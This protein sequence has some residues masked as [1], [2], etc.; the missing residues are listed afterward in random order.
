MVR[1]ARV[2]GRAALSGEKSSNQS[3]YPE[4]RSGEARGRQGRRESLDF[5]WRIRNTTYLLPY[6]HADEL[7]GHANTYPGRSHA[8]RRHRVQASLRSD[9]APRTPGRTERDERHCSL[10]AAMQITVGSYVRI[11]EQCRTRAVRGLLCRVQALECRRLSA[12]VPT[13]FAKVRVLGL[14][15]HI[16]G[17][18]P[19]WWMPCSSI[20]YVAD[21]SSCIGTQD[22][23]AAASGFLPFL[24]GCNR[25]STAAIE[26][27]LEV[28]RVRWQ[29]MSVASRLRQVRACAQGL[30][31]PSRRPG[32]PAPAAFCV[33]AEGAS[34]LTDLGTAH[35]VTGAVSLHRPR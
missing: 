31:S 5:A 26:S 17:D 33:G 14:E 35:P 15:E 16:Q 25:L 9:I 13:Q 3:S 1:V 34:P 8:S 7:P 29:M 28:S 12:F 27:S 18:A 21:A 11:E 22:A 20:C 24:F 19:E 30:R 32:R 6:L 2:R 10:P 4:R 23:Q